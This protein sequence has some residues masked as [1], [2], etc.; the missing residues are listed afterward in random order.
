MGGNV[1]IAKRRIDV[2]QGKVG[3]QQMVVISQ[4]CKRVDGIVKAV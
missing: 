3:E 4:G 2:E 1:R